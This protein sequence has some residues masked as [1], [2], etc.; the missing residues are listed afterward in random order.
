M[1]YGGM[2]HALEQIHGLLKADGSLVDIHPVPDVAVIKVLNA[3]RQVFSE[4]YP[5]QSGEDFRAADRAIELIL[6]RNLF[7]LERGTIFDFFTYAS[8]ASELNDFFATA[9]AYDQR[10]QEGTVEARRAELF[11]R[12]DQMIMTAGPGAELVYHERVRIARL[13]PIT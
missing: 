4:Q 12:V 11:A 8:S 5:S 7:H 13:K 1:E 2:V 6:R 10:P 9:D 3:G